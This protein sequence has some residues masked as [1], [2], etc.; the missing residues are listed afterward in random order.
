MKIRFMVSFMAR[1]AFRTRV[2]QK[3]NRSEAELKL[4]TFISLIIFMA[5][6]QILIK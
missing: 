3:P 2:S 4:F 6:F 5:F 1:N